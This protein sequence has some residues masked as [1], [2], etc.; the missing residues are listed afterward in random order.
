LNFP[1]GIAVQNDGT[2]IVAEK[3]QNRLQIFDRDGHLKQ[4]IGEMGKRD[5]QF[6]CPSSLVLDPYGYLFVVDT[7]NQRIQKFDP[8]LNFVAKWGVIGKEEGQFKDPAGIGLSWE[9]DWAPTED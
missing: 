5:G 8:D 3:S 1:N 9:P 4:V 6:N 7:I 2:I